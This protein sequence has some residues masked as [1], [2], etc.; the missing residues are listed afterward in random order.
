MEVMMPITAMTVSISSSEKPCLNFDEGVVCI[1]LISSI[2]E[3]C[4]NYRN[5]TSDRI[6]GPKAYCGVQNNPFSGL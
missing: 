2:T 4:I 5:F 1:E 6:N 3:I